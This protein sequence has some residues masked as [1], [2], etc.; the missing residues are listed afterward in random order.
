MYSYQAHFWR[1]QPSLNTVVCDCDSEPN[2]QPYSAASIEYHVIHTWHD[3]PPCQCIMPT[4]QKSLA[5]PLTL[6]SL[7]HI[8]IVLALPLTLSSLISSWCMFVTVSPRHNFTVLL[9]WNILSHKW[10]DTPADHSILTAG[11]PILA[12]PQTLNSV[13]HHVRPNS[14]SYTELSLSHI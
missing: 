11:L 6:N 3:N 12:L 14:L 1:I 13:L 8:I 7:S 5:L 2:A 4:G 9:Y 10:H